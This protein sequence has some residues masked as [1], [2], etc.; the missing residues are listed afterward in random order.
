M[1]S[2]IKSGNSI[3]DM[4]AKINLDK[5]PHF[6]NKLLDITKIVKMLE[7]RYSP[8]RLDNEFNSMLV[9][10]GIISI[11]DLIK[12]YYKDLVLKTLYTT[13]VYNF[14]DLSKTDIYKKQLDIIIKGFYEEKIVEFVRRYYEIKEDKYENIETDKSIPDYYMTFLINYMIEK[15]II[16]ELDNNYLNYK[17]DIQVHMTEL[18]TKTLDFAK[19][20]VD[21]YHRYMVNLYHSMKTFDVL[22]K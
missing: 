19:V 2:T 21:T 14:S 17:Q 9:T 16:S 4:L 7:Q 20:I 5:V 6:N 12:V 11:T 3:N 15:G 10:I 22:T 1:N 13:N 18:I 8:K